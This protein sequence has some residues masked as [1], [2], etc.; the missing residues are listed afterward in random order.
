MKRSFGLW[1][2]ICFGFGIVSCIDDD[3]DNSEQ[4]LAEQTA[5]IDAYLADHATG[6]IVNDINGVRMD[7]HQLGKGLPAKETS[8]I[9][10]KYV[11][12]LFDDNSLFEQGTVDKKV[13]N[14]LIPGWQIALVSLP[15]GSKA[16]VYIPSKWAYGP[17]GQGAI[18]GNAVLKFE[19]EFDKINRSSAELQ[20]LG[21][22]TIAIDNYLASKSVVAKK[23]STGL[24]YVINTEG[25]GP[26]P[27]L[28]DQVSFHVVM[29]LLTA[30]DKVVLETDVAP[31]S[32]NYNR[33]VDQY[34]DGMKLGVQKLR[35]GGKGTFYVPSSLAWGT[36]GAS[37][38]SGQAIIPADANLII[39]IELD[40]IGTP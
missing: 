26:T 16:D 12:R 31:S 23:D 22:D 28:Y 10:V 36:R 15:E 4:L 30:D 19:L 18:P 38:A 13:L 7:I 1:V 37:N 33:V 17:S 27:T 6:L 21:T 5:A 3:G 29:K 25:T 39:E 20:K 40:D 32:L 14:T 35:K 8:N 11:G 24:R 9:N 2:L 34:A